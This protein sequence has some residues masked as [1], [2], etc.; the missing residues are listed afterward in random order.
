MGVEHKTADGNYTLYGLIEGAIQKN[1]ISYGVVL[2]G[3]CVYDPS[4]GVDACQN[5]DGE[6]FFRKLDPANKYKQSFYATSDD[7]TK[8]KSAGTET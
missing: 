3:T 8:N 2:E 1:E 5:K 6:K 4:S 7:V